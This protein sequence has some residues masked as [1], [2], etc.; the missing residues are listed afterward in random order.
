VHLALDDVGTGW[1]LPM[2]DGGVAPGFGRVG[3]IAD[4]RA[5]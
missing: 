1:S 2:L 4:R 5:V 3:G